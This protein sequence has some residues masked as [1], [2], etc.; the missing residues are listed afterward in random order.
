[1]TDSA[2]ERSAYPGR[3]IDEAIGDCGLKLCRGGSPGARVRA[4]AQAGHNLV[5]IL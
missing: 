3:K 5:A 2:L 4:P 1:M